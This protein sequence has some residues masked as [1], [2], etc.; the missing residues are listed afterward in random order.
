MGLRWARSALALLLVGGLFMITTIQLWESGLRISR[1][2]PATSRILLQQHQSPG[3]ITFEPPKLEPLL[4]LCPLLSKDKLV[5]EVEEQ[6]P[7]LLLTYW[8]SASR[9]AAKP[10]ETPDCAAGYPSV[11]E[12]E[13]ND[14]YWQTLRSSNG[15][16]QLFGAFFDKRRLSL[17]GP[18]VRI[19]GMID[20]VEPQVK[21]FCQLW[22]EGERK[23]QVVE[24]LESQYVWHHY[25]GLQVQGIY[26]PYLITCTVPDSHRSRGPPGSVSLVERRCETAHNNLWVIYNKPEHKKP[27]AVCVKG[28]DFPH[29]DLSARLVEWIELIGLLGAE[30]IFFYELQVHP[31]V[32]KVL[33]HYQRLGRIHVTPLSLPGGSRTCRLFSTCTSVRSRV[34]RC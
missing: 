33:Q 30:K 15:T 17:I 6:L 4:D 24:V 11:F 5:R 7:S 31:N 8:K 16:F 23:P 25:W 19:V 34:G 2:G 29:V 1:M 22:Y 28:L 3:P 10:G 14:I 27:F 21:T 9:L 20:R 26:Q 18:A 13:F 32:T 12:L